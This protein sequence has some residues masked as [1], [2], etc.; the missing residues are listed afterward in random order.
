MFLIKT[1]VAGKIRDYF[2]FSRF[3]YSMYITLSSAVPITRAYEISAGSV[4]GYI[5]RE[6]LRSQ[7]EKLEKGVSISS[8]LKATGLFEPLFI[9]LVET[10]ENSGELEKM[11]KL[12]AEIYRRESL[13]KINLWVRLV[14]PLSIL[15]IG[16]VVGVIVLSVLLP[17]TEITAGIGR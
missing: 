6:R 15:I 7:R 17:L 11:F 2:D 8:V 16:I 12:L 10:G 14:E 3:A 4:S 13:R 9:N 1:P 5:L